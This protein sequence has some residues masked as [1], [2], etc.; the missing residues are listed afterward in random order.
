MEALREVLSQNAKKNLCLKPILIQFEAE[1]DEKQSQDGIGPGGLHPIFLDPPGP[2]SVYLWLTDTLYRGATPQL[3]RV[4]L[5]EKIIEITG[6]VERECRGV[7][8]R[9][10]KVLEQLAAQQSA[11]VS[12]PQDTWELDRALAHIFEYQKVLVDEANRTVVFIPDNP[13]M[14]VADRPVW[15]I[16]VGSRTVF[17]KGQEHD[18]RKALPSWLEDRQTA[19]WT[20][21]WPDADGSLE[22]LKQRAAALGVSFRMEK[23]KKQDYSE[24]LGKVE[25]MKRLLKNSTATN[26]D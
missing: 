6:D 23:P 20:V 18:C 19:G 25:S 17:H 24:K 7:K 4:M 9:R 13:A 2:V 1:I 12:P 14:W 8:W 3:R 22:E 26:G 11:A 16:G 15:I 10:P 5:R 21:K